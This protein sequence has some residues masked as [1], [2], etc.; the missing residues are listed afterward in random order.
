MLFQPFIKKFTGNLDAQGI[1]GQLTAWMGSNQV[2]NAC[3]LMLSSMKD[4]QLFQTD[5]AVLLIVIVEVLFILKKKGD[6][7]MEK[8]KYL[9]VS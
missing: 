5:S 9:T 3:E 8:R 4:K 1:I 6:K 2:L 7:K